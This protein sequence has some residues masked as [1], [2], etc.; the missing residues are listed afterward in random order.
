MT[1]R[2]KRIRAYT[3]D[4][5]AYPVNSKGQRILS[6]RITATFKQSV[7]NA[8]ARVNWIHFGKEEVVK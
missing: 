1:T 3:F 8:G 7:N 5:N 6:N 2:I 4:K